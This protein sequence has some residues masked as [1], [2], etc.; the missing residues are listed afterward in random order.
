MPNSIAEQK[1]QLRKEC[2][3]LRKAL[4]EAARLKS[5]HA[6]GGLIENWPEFQRAQ[7]ILTYMPIPTEVDLR[8]LLE[9]HPQKRWIL[10]RIIPEAD[11]SMIFHPYDPN[12]L[13]RHPFGMA[14]PAPDSPTISAAE[15]QLSLVPGLAFD[16]FGWRLGYGGG[17]FDRF[18][19]DFNGTSLGVVYDE[20]MLEN[21]PRNQFDVAM[22]WL[23]TEKGL[24]KTGGDC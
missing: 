9:S 12:R 14:E 11:H 13:I 20:L 5:S 4:G 23:V 17:Y 3:Q 8:P 24:F 16:R 7:T 21:L 2:R 15:I 22:K 10:P 1:S 18:L 6:I 19:K